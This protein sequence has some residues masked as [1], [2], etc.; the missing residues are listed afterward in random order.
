[1]VRTW[2]GEPGG[3]GDLVA[4]GTKISAG[5]DKTPG[6]K[7]GASCPTAPP[8]GRA[9]LWGSERKTVLFVCLFKD[10]IPLPF[11]ELM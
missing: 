1:M 6:R 8:P 11:K 7:K 4:M 10:D 9:S 3:Q 5:E 2:A